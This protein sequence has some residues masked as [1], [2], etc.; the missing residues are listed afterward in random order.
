M[1]R[2]I[3]GAGQLGGEEEGEGLMSWVVDAVD[4]EQFRMSLLENLVCKLRLRF[5][6]SSGSFRSACSCAC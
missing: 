2:G 3:V 4:P 5:G 1:Q 6:A